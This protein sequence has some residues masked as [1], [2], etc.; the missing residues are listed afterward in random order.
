[1]PFTPGQVNE[2]TP[3]QSDS[4]AAICT[5]RAL[6]KKISHHSRLYKEQKP[7]KEV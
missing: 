7:G 5:W 2:E 4:C 6:E 3:V 1:M